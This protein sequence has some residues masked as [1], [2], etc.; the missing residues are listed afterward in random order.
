MS[1]VTHSNIYGHMIAGFIE[2]GNSAWAISVVLAPKSDVK[3][4]VFIGYRADST[5]GLYLIP[6]LYRFCMTELIVF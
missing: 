1:A 6:N 5:K 2:P 4:P 3:L